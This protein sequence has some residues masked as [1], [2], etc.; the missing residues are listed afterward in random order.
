MRSNINY[1]TVKEIGI[2]IKRFRT[3]KK[4]TQYELA[5]KAEL[6]QTQISM[7]ESGRRLPF[8]LNVIKIAI[9]LQCSISSIVFGHIRIHKRKFY[10]GNYIS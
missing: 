10:N 2:N 3:N 4:Y 5:E 9:A 6:S 1:P 7:Y 8:L